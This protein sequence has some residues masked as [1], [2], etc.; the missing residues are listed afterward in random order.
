MLPLSYILNHERHLLSWCNGTG[1]H[2]P[3]I[4][5]ICC[6]NPELQYVRLAATIQNNMSNLLQRQAATIRNYVPL[7]NEA[8]CQQPDRFIW[9]RTL[10]VER[11]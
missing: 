7:T 6:K 10:G 2:N 4:F 3:A 9:W 11:F 8:G 1:C 5:E